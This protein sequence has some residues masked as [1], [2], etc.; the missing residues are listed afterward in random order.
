M[1]SILYEFEAQ[2]G[3]PLE[4][5]RRQRHV[6]GQELERVLHLGRI[7]RIREVQRSVDHLEALR[8]AEDV[9]EPFEVPRIRR[10][11]DLPAPL[12]PQVRL[13]GRDDPDGARRPRHALEEAAPEGRIVVGRPLPDAG[14]LVEAGANADDRLQARLVAPVENL[15]KQVLR[16]RRLAVLVGEQDRDVAPGAAVG[17]D[18]LAG[19]PDEARLVEPCQVEADDVVGRRRQ[20]G[21]WFGLPPCRRAT[22]AVRLRAAPRGLVDDSES[23]AAEHGYRLD[24]SRRSTHPGWAARSVPAR[25]ACF[26]VSAATGASQLGERNDLCPYRPRHAV[27]AQSQHSKGCYHVT[28]FCRSSPGTWRWRRP[29]DHARADALRH[30]PGPIPPRRREPDARLRAKPGTD[31]VAGSTRLSTRPGSASITARAGRRSPRRRSSSPPPPS[32]P[33]TSSSARASSACRTTTR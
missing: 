1:P 9:D 7:V 27:G 22:E 4:D 26:R 3:Q 21:L 31:P 24:R 16:R 6:L 10:D 32:G 17:V 2:A 11:V 13:V 8:I 12:A 29:D 25:R 15:L 14:L 5:R 19:G 30:L 20:L 18:D 28:T 23:E 33:A